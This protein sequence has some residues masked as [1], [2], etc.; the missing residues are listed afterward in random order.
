MVEVAIACHILTN[1]A[2]RLLPPLITRT[3]RGG[4]KKK[5]LARKPVMPTNN[6]SKE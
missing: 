1:T 2:C 5:T 4:D 6:R 3:A